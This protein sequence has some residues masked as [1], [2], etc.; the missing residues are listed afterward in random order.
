MRPSTAARSTQRAPTRSS[1][2]KNSAAKQ[3]AELDRAVAQSRKLGCE[4][5]GFFSLFTGQGPQC[6]PL[7]S[8][9]QQM[10]GNSTRRSSDLERLKSNTGDQS[11]QRNAVLTQL[12]QNDC[13]PQYRTAATGPGGFFGQLFGTIISPGGDGAPSGTYRTVCVRTCDGYYFPISYSTVPSR[14]A[15]D[16]RSCQRLCPASEAVLYSYRNPGEDM[17][18]AVSVNGQPYTELPNA[19][20]YRKEFNAAC[21]CRRAGQS[22]ADALKNADDRSTIEQGDIVVTQKNAKAL[23]QAPQVNGAGQEDPARP[24]RPQ[25]P[26]PSTPAR[27]RRQSR[28][29]PEETHGAHRRSDV[30]DAGAAMMVTAGRVIAA[31]SESKNRMPRISPPLP[32]LSRREIGR[33]RLRA[34]IA[35]TVRNRIA[36][37]A[38]E[39]PERHLDARRRLPPLVFGD[40]EHAL[41]LH[42]GVAI[43]PGRDDGGNRLL[44]LDQPLQDLVENV[45]RRQRVLVGLVF[46]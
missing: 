27:H 25:T 40:I 19:F 20:R 18:Q 16:Q 36:P 4:G 13:G 31:P 10:R 8:H 32:V 11:A 15:D 45:V 7:N 28:Y 2:T 42:H 38:A 12:A 34:G 41:D 24:S 14:F 1:V 35:K 43:E 22:W 26:D 23:S 3:Q 37:V 5:L 33:S 9:I 6:F 30:Y 17:Q 44:A 46:A 21:S 39:I 29:G